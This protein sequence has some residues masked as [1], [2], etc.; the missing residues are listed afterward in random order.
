[1]TV[2]VLDSGCGGLSILRALEHAFPTVRFVY[3][4]DY[5]FAPYSE[6]PTPVLQERAAF[7]IAKLTQEHGCSHIVIACNT[8]TVT[9]ISYARQLFPAIAIIGTVPPVKVAADT[10]PAKSK[11]LVLATKNTVQSPYLHQLIQLSGSPLSFFL[12]GSTLLVKCIEQQDTAATATELDRMIIPYA[13]Q[14]QAVVVGCTHFSFVRDLI[15]A[16]CT[17]DTRILEPQK[18]IIDRCR[19]LFL[20][21]NETM[22][23][24]PQTLLY[25]T[26]PSQQQHLIKM[27]EL[28]VKL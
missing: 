25:S 19:T 10:L 3:Y 14:I 18:G 17:P 24:A 21:T 4:A 28:S 16:R 11:V 23:S 20:M 12:E 22:H 1:M 8:L 6:K 15:A 26:E 2:G 13:T 5:A 9:S 27:Y 7:L